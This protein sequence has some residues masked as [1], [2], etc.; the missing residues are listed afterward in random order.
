[1]PR[2]ENISRGVTYNDQTQVVTLLRD[3]DDI[4]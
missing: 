4:S 2:S 1:M 3:L